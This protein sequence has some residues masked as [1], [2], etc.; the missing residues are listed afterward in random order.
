MICR[1]DSLGVNYKRK[2]VFKLIII[3]EVKTFRRG[4]GG[5]GSKIE[6][7]MLRL[8]IHCNQNKITKLQLID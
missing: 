3:F 8:D 1:C 6:Q 7:T 4:G 5:K 2:R